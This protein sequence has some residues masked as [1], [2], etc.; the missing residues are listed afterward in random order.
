MRR[1]FLV[2]FITVSFFLSPLWGQTSKEDDLT[3]DHCIAIALQQNPLVLSSLQQYQASLARVNQAKAFPQPSIGFDS[4]LQPKFFNFKDSGE[5]Y[6]GLSQS[7]EFPGKRYLRG[8]IASKESLE[9]MQ[10]ID[11]L[12]LDLGFQVK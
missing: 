5:S 2:L 6:F 9:L 7:I 11:L 4:D 10:E 8:K 3:L 12:K 1:K